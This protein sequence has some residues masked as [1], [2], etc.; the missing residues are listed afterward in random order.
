MAES[1]AAV[2]D[3]RSAVTIFDGNRG[4]AT[5]PFKGT[6]YSI[7]LYTVKGFETLQGHQ[8]HLAISYVI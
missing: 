7:V 3:I 5:K 8:R 4:H 6:R 1:E 2:L